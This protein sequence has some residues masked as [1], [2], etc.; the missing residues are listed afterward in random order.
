MLAVAACSN[1]PAV[2]GT[3]SSTTAGAS[4]TTTTVPPEPTTTTTSLIGVSTEFSRAVVELDGSPLTVAVAD[5]NDERSRGLMGVEA[6]SPLDGMLFVFENSTIRSFWMKDTLIPLDI[7]FFDEDGFLVS[8]TTMAVC[9]EDDCP[10]YSSEAPARYALEAPAGSL[11]GLAGDA[12]L[13][14]IGALDG[15]GKE[16]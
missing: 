8:Q 14:I 6:L 5:T 15:S 3:T 13:V 4:A 1:E 9:P 11:S 7:A 10:R 12:R 16:I 2:D